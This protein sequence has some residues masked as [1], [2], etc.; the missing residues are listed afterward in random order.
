MPLRSLIAMNSLLVLRNSGAALSHIVRAEENR[1]LKLRRRPEA[2]ETFLYGGREIEQ[3]I[4]S[5]PG[6]DDLNADR[7]ALWRLT[8]L[9]GERRRMQRR[10]RR[11]PIENVRI[12]R[13][14]A[15]EI[16]DAV[17]EARLL[18]MGKGSH[19]RNRHHDGVVALEELGK[20]VFVRLLFDI[21]CGD[22]AIA[23]GGA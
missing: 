9:H 4:L 8:C 23:R 15:V 1:Q 10:R 6:T 18:L 21:R 11:N 22:L 5:V 12:G 7:H 3:T 14:L 16:E 13:G 17:L 20:L 19:H 2:A